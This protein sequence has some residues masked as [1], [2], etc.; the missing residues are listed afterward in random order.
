MRRNA[1][2]VHEDV[3][4]PVVVA[5]DEVARRGDEGDIA[6]RRADRQRALRRQAG[7]AAVA[8]RLRSVRPHRDARRCGQA[9]CRRAVARVAQE[10]VVGIVGI[11]GHQVR[12]ARGE[13]DV[14]TEKVHAAIHARS[15]RIRPIERHADPLRD[16]HNVGCSR[17]GEPDRVAPPAAGRRI[18]NLDAA[19]SGARHV[20]CQDGGS[21]FDRAQI[22]RLARRTIPGHD[23]QG[24]V[25]LALH[26]QRECRT[27]SDH[28]RRNQGR[29]DGRHD[30]RV[31][32]VDGERQ[33][34]GRTASG[35][36]AH[37]LHRVAPRGREIGGQQGCVESCGTD[38]RGR[39]VG[40]VPLHEGSRHKA[41]AA[42]RDS[43]RSAAGQH[44]RG[45]Q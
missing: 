15:V 10:D 37:H 1:R 14:A 2:V 11:A 35:R 19:D 33:G 32:R 24:D 18:C 17:H 30:R 9:A 25:A 20:S 28:A 44:P 34:C 4:D 29:D 6:A 8:I 27:A 45:T 31:G 16:L 26:G 23:G 41:A 38:E 22:G 13:D 43:R 3:V 39:A 5:G 21:Q 42:H 7:G 40:A 36:W 12:C